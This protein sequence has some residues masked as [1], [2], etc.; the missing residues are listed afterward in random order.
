MELRCSTDTDSG[1]PLSPSMLRLRIDK[2]KK[3][4]ERLERLLLTDSGSPRNQSSISVEEIPVNSPRSNQ[5][6]P[7]TL[8]TQNPQKDNIHSDPVEELKVRSTKSR[9][10][11]KNRA[12]STKLG[13]VLFIFSIFNFYNYK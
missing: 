7:R 13:F 4:V 1:P 9:K 2:L 11:R 12:K 10:H 6:E 3:E 5:Q 8:L